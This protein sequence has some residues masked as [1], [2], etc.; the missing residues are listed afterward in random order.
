MVVC[1]LSSFSDSYQEFNRIS[2]YYREMVIVHPDVNFLD[3]IAGKLREVH[4]CCHKLLNFFPLYHFLYLFRWFFCQYTSLHFVVI[5]F[6][7]F[8]VILFLKK[9]NF[10]LF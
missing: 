7:L 1:A 8:N 6:L 4:A 9:K 5:K 10:P 2:C 3:D